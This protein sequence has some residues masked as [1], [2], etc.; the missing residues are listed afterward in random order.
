MKIVLVLLITPPYHHTAHA[1]EH[2]RLFAVQ[3]WIKTSGPPLDLTWKSWRLVE[4]NS[5]GSVTQLLGWHGG[6]L[7][8]NG[9]NGRLI[10]AQYDRMA[11]SRQLLV[12]RIDG[13]RMGKTFNVAKG[14]A[15]SAVPIAMP[16]L[17][18]ETQGFWTSIAADN[19]QPANTI[20]SLYDGLDIGSPQHFATINASRV[21]GSSHLA[22]N[23]R[24]GGATAATSLVYFSLRP[25]TGTQ[26]LYKMRRDN[27]H[28][29]ELPWSLLSKDA[30]N[31]TVGALFVGSTD[32]ELLVLGCHEAMQQQCVLYS[33]DTVQKTSQAVL[34]LPSLDPGPASGYC[35]SYHE[36]SNTLY[37]GCSKVHAIDLTN[38]K[39][40]S[41]TTISFGMPLNGG[42]YLCGGVVVI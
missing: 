19:V 36:L 9:N 32:D 25:F 30:I 1:N 21:I 38:K 28:V 22:H 3:N 8:N 29:E 40:K 31:R 13:E 18:E 20:F 26:R 33:L 41:I 2:P 23:R 27:A 11:Q 14:A 4:V 42:T 10:G 35:K 17:T 34:N 39:L 24:P 37:L 6:W 15:G 16:G 12:V 7:P 5:L